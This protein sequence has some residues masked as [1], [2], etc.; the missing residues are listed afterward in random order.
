M[1]VGQTLDG[2][3]HYSVIAA[4]FSSEKPSLPVKMKVTA[5]PYKQSRD[6]R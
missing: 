5:Y 2:P 1:N 3:L 4:A 6:V